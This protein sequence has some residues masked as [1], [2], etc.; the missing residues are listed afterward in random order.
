VGYVDRLRGLAVLAM[1]FV[2]SGFAW[3]LPAVRDG[4]TYGSAVAE[5]AGMVAPVFMFL[6]GVSVALVF[7]RARRSGVDERATVKRV[8]IRGWQILGIG[9]GLGLSFL[10][11]GA[12]PAQWQKMLRV[13]ILQCIGLSLALMP[14]C[15]RS[16]RRR[17]WPALV[18][19]G[20]LALGAQATWRLPLG[21]WLPDFLAGFLTREVPNSRFPLFPYAAWVAL[22]LFV[23]PLWLAAVRDR[24]R[25]RRFWIGTVVASLVAVGLSLIGAWAH[26][27]FGLDRLG[28]GGKAPVTTVHFFLFKTGAVLLLFAAARITAPLLDRFKSGPLVLIGRTSL[29]A[30]C[31]HLVL[32]YHLFGP[33]WLGRLTPWEQILGALLLTA[34]MLA[35]CGA[36]RRWPPHTWAAGLRRLRTHR[37]R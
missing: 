12:F 33:F 29:F 37:A 30:Y 5:I 17:N 16:R 19:Y 11:F 21:D 2:H 34:L 7:E 3:L 32:I 25:E 24:R 23:G 10:V 28:P 8:S 35:L 26:V 6:A 27:R 22:G 14:W 4:S 1:F 18:A 20:V 15:C 13:D 31:V 9:Y 36:W